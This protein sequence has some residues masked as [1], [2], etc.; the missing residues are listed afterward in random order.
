MINKV[1]H[2]C[3]FGE[4]KIDKT[5]ELC[6]KSWEEFLPDFSKKKWSEEN[7]L[8][9]NPF[10]RK[11]FKE[12]KWAFLADYFRLKAL[13]SEGGIYLD[14]D[15]LLVK[16]LNPLLNE[17]CFLGFEST[18]MVSAGIIGAVPNHPFIRRCLD[19]YDN[20]NDFDFLNPT[21]IPIVITDQLKKNGLEKYGGQ[22]IGEV[23]LFPIDYFYPYTYRDHLL[24]K[25]SKE[26][27]TE[28]T[29]AVHLWNAS[30]QPPYYK[31]SQ[32]L[33]DANFAGGL[34][35]CL[36]T[37]Y[38]KPNCLAKA[39]YYKI[40]IKLVMGYLRYLLRLKKTKK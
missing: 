25:N 36:K 35:E 28:N 1:I 14:T 7:C 17:K 13:Y 39:G 15:M 40:F 2:Y 26:K 29:F 33:K 12:K 31:A 34:K 20:L 23:M 24:G 37:G 19:F 9:D 10:V 30:W 4:N 3:W 27:I 11:S 22:N 38:Q 21:S 8:I 16:S 5:S 18:D 6:M 32:L